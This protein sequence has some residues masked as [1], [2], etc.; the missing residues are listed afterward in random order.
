MQLIIS[1]VLILSPT[2]AMNSI[3]V[4]IELGYMVAIS[5]KFHPFLSLYC[6]PCNGSLMHYCNIE[7]NFCV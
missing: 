2:M 1:S 3:H 7:K 5:K 6:F 4:C